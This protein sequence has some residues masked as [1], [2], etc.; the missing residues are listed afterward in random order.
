MKILLAGITLAVFLLSSC[1]LFPRRDTVAYP[2]NGGPGGA[3][4]SIYVDK[5]D[6]DR[7]V[8]AREVAKDVEC[9]IDVLAPGSGFVV[10]PFS[11]PEAWP[12]RVHVV[13]RETIRDF[14]PQYAIMVSLE[15]FPSADAQTP[16]LTVVHTCESTD[17]VSSPWVL[18]QILN[19]C[20][21]EAA[22]AFAAGTKK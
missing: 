7:R 11:S 14:T 12:L 19:D 17:T 9:L 22:R 8:L 21:H 16:A 4:A 15:M 5:V 1:A 2:A 6:V 3:P 13:E 10:A 18:K 20:F